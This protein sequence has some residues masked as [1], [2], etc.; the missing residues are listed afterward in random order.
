VSR[1]PEAGDSLSFSAPLDQFY[2]P[3]ALL[4]HPDEPLVRD[5]ELGEH[6]ER[7]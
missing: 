5:V 7:E 4:A 3:E 2:E 6:D 1:R